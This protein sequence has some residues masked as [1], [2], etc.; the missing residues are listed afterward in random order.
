[1][2]RPTYTQ[3]RLIDVV[4]SAGMTER[5]GVR[6]VEES[7]S[8]NALVNL[9]RELFTTISGIGVLLGFVAVAFTVAQ[10]SYSIGADEVATARD[11]R[12]RAEERARVAEQARLEAERT[13]SEQA[14]VI[15]TETV[16]ER[17]TEPTADPTGAE[18]SD[19]AT[20]GPRASETD[21]SKTPGLIYDVSG[22]L[23]NGRELRLPATEGWDLDEW[24]D[25]PDRN[26]DLFYTGASLYAG[27][28]QD[29]Q[30]VWAQAVV[31]SGEEAA[32]GVDKCRSTTGYTGYNDSRASIGFQE[33][34]YACVRTDLGGYALVYYVE[35]RGGEVVFN[36]S[37][38]PS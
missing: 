12:D 32:Q 37:F 38:W 4:R 13:A 34:E 14:T 6:M 1:M 15:V 18:S 20:A 16:T 23:Y 26:V 33:G 35:S 30:S 29:A 3:A 36:V 27:P 5:S 21:S 8:R 28:Q 7:R 2:A 11:E 10:L 25:E 19:G 31:I 9:L 24:S 22:S 17:A